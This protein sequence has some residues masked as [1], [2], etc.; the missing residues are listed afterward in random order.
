M[1]TGAFNFI[2]ADQNGISYRSSPAVPDRGTPGTFPPPWKVLDGSDP[3]T[4]WTGELLP[5]DRLPRSRGGSRGWLASA[6]N[7]P[8]GFVSDGSI[9]GDEFYFGVFFDPGS[10]AQRISDELE[11]FI[12]AGDVT[13]E[14]MKALQIDTHSVLADEML[15]FLFAAADALDEDETL[16]AYRDRP[17]LSE[18]L[19]LLRDWD[20]D[21]DRDSRG[22]LAFEVFAAQL[23]RTVLV[24]DLSPTLL[25]AV[26][27]ESPIYI[28]KWAVLALRSAPSLVEEGN[29]A[30]SYQALAATAEYLA[31]IGAEETWGDRH[32]LR[33]TSEFGGRFDQGTFPLA[34]GN[35]TVNV[36][37]TKVLA[38]GAVA[39][40]FTTNGGAIYRMVAGFSESG[41]PEAQFAFVG[42]NGGEPGGEHW[43]DLT[44]DWLEGRYRPLYFEEAEIEAATTARF[45]VTD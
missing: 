38:D 6:N 29:H 33:L 18:T 41:R 31:S 43:D 35:G 40:I 8:Y 20:R 5:L 9:E 13:L 32:V 15:P 27:A 42:G 25:D 17:E 12:A 39:D 14:Q 3:A 45:T 37:Q 26:Y 44:A 11:R 10:R 7:D 2:A 28:Y 30:A 1:T 19:T 23:A 36:A 24:D 34:G 4:V 22:A 16:A 21:M